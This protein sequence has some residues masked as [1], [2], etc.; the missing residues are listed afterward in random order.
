VPTR[1][2]GICG[3]LAFLTFNLAWIAGGQ[4][5]PSAYSVANDDI[6]DLGAIHGREPVGLRPGRSEPHRHPA[7][8]A[9]IGLT[10]FGGALLATAVLMS[11]ARS[12]VSSRRS[13]SAVLAG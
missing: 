8:W 11:A 1:I 13:A 10:L 12:R 5:Q 6:S 9:G 4:V 2:A 3:L 7:L